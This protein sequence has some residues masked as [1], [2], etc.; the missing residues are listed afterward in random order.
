M[1]ANITVRTPPVPVADRLDEDGILLAWSLEN[2]RQTPPVGFHYGTTD[3]VDA[4][5]FLQPILHTGGGHLMSF[6]PTGAG[7]GVGA[8]IPTLLRYPGPVIVIDPKGENYAVTARCRREMGHET[9]CLDPFNSIEDKHQDAC[10]N[11]LD[12]IDAQSPTAADDAQML[13]EALSYQTIMGNDPFWHVRGKQLLAGLIL[14][15]ATARPPILRTLAEVAYLVN[16]PAEDFNLTLKEM[17]NSTNTTVR[18]VVGIIDNSAEKM[19]ASIQAMTQAN[20]GFLNSELI[21]QVVARTDF[22]IDSITRGDP[23]S[24]YLIIPPEKLESH[25][26]LLRI[27]ISCLM[28]LILRRRTAVPQRTLFILDE[29]AQLGN[30]PPLRQ[31]ITLLRG[32]GLQTWSF[33]QDLSQLQRLYPDDWE[34][35]YNNCRAHQYFGITTPYL[36]EQISKLSMAHHPQEIL[37]LDAD[38]MLLTLAGDMPV[39]AQRPNYLTDTP[40]KGKF[41]PNPYHQ[42]QNLK[43]LQP[44]RG[45][46]LYHRQSLST[47]FPFSGNEPV[48]P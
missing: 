7:K 3:P 22:S 25:A 10:F 15:I 43:Q 24:V 44:V 11:P 47:G 20:M 35:M 23:V 26:P 8:V 36:A 18:Q 9:V 42:E 46:R 6:A 12:L 39:I 28:K 19:S 30:F 21:Q 27:W 17:A 1:T 37:E 33:W 13:A 31:A 38:E 41:D 34:T 2:S 4:D 48:K 45:Q 40:F 29:A 32:Y 16:Q 5:R 14:H